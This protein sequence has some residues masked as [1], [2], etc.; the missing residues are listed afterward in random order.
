MRFCR[1]MRCTPLRPADGP[2]RPK[3]PSRSPQKRPRA[4]Q[5]GPRA[6]QEA[7]KT[8]QRKPKLSPRGLQDAQDGLQDGQ[9]GLR[10]A[11]GCTQHGLKL[12]HP[13]R[14]QDTSKTVQEASKRSFRKARRRQN[15]RFPLVFDRF[16]Y[17][18]LLGLRR[19]KTAQKATKIAPR[20]P[21]RPPRWP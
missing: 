17:L 4:L 6:A 18:L 21:K 19:P 12:V 14:P 5:D 8:A 13:R 16:G 10:R 9:D 2:S 11:P 3:R 1:M 15:Q 20:A 7:P